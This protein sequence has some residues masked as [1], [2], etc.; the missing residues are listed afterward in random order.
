MVEKAPLK[1][2]DGVSQI[3]EI[4]ELSQND[5]ALSSHI[6]E[7]LSMSTQCK[8]PWTMY[9]VQNIEHPSQ[10]NLIDNKPSLFLF[11]LMS[12]VCISYSIRNQIKAN[13]WQ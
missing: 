3:I 11:H 4:Q 2:S 13:I 8:C 1:H 9:K 7:E 12:F 6:S 5:W 10:N